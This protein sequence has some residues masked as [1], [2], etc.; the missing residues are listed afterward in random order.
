MAPTSVLAHAWHPADDDGERRAAERD[1]LFELSADLLCVAGFDGYFKQL[2]PAWADTFDYSD[3]ELMSAPFIE[4]VHPEDREATRAEAA[5][6]AAGVETIEFENRYRCRNGAYRWLSWT[7]RGVLATEMLYGCA[8]DVTESRRAD[9]A[10][11]ALNERLEMASRLK[12]EFLANMSHE[13]RTPLCS[14]IGF[15]DLLLAGMEGELTEPQRADVAIIL[16]SGR[17][18]LKLIND[19]LDLSKIEAGEMELELETVDLLPVVHSVITAQATVAQ[20]KNISLVT[21]V[22]ADALLARADELR[23]RQVLTN[24][25]AN[26]IKFTEAGEVRV[27]CQAEGS[28]VI[29]SIIDTGIGIAPEARE[30]IFDEFRQA[31]TG[32]TRRFGGTGLGL[33]ISRHL[34][35]AQGGE[36]TVESWP[37]TGSIFRFTLPRSAAH[38]EVVR[39]K[40]T[41]AWPG[42]GATVRARAMR[43]HSQPAGA[44]PGGKG[45]GGR[46]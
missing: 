27:R 11:H 33:S 2:N 43:N 9:Q 40:L 16:S 31:E 26:A 35:E 17:G 36:L 22:P 38:P 45:C 10:M 37:G 19:I 23:V 4:F 25:V 39:E 13:L 24:L 18:L 44:G 21:E 32:T 29:T 5:K 30:F 15:S 34:V 41:V 42:L 6:L 8:R 3:D 1:H 12:S 20:G 14:I 28:Q 46:G 7:V